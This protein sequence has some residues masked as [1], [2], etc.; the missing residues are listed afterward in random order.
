MTQELMSMIENFS[1][2]GNEDRNRVLKEIPQEARKA[3]EEQAFF[4]E[5]FSDEGFY[6]AVERAIGR[7]VYEAFNS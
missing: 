7:A 3:I 5:L 6:N 4:Y 1:L 2:L